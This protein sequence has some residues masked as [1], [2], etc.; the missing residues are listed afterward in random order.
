LGWDHFGRFFSQTHPV[1]LV[2]VMA[3]TIVAENALQSFLGL[4][5]PKFVARNVQNIRVGRRK[6]SFAKIVAASFDKFTS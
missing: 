3:A 5:L 4:L 2:V 6:K 1:T